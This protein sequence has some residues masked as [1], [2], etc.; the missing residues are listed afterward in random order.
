MSS[1][2]EE[3]AAP[4]EVVAFFSE[5]FNPLINRH[6][7]AHFVADA[8]R[9]LIGKQ[10]LA[11]GHSMAADNGRYLPLG[12]RVANL[13][14]GNLRSEA[15]SSFGIGGRSSAALLVTGL[16]GRAATGSVCVG[17]P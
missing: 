16:A 8:L 11:V 9:L 2:V 6:D 7:A 4:L 13:M 12:Q 5:L 14:S 17:A 15:N 3:G 10:E 1:L